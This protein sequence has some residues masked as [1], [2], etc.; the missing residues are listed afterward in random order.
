M[1]DFSDVPLEEIGGLVISPNSDIPFGKQ[2]RMG[3]AEYTIYDRAV[4]Q[5]YNAGILAHLQFIQD[6]DNCAPVMLDDVS[7]TQVIHAF[8]PAGLTEHNES[9][10]SA[11]FIAGWV[12]VGLGLVREVEEQA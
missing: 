9:V 5:G 8:V 11:H 6:H 1:S 12:S 2:F 3:L 7:F 4:E 10:W